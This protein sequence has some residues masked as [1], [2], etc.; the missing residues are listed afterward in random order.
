MPV[1]RHLTSTKQLDRPWVEDGLFAEC[2]RIRS[3]GAV[4]DRL[5]G[6]SLYCLFYEPSFLTRTS[7]E[8]A[9]GL[10]GGIAYHTESVSGQAARSQFFPVRR[11]TTRRTRPSSSRSGRRISSTT[12]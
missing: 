11:H 1:D 4:G 2:E 3:G 9:I 12:R 8:R 6:L 7:F 5:R 10:L